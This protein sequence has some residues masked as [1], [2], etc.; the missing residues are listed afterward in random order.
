MRTGNITVAEVDTE[1]LKIVHKG[2]PTT[3]R[4]VHPSMIGAHT[5]RKLLNSSQAEATTAEAEVSETEEVSKEC[6][7]EAV[8]TCQ[9]E[10]EDAAT[11]HSGETAVAETSEV[12]TEAIITEVASMKTKTRTTTISKRLTECMMMTGKETLLNESHTRRQTV[13]FERQTNIDVG[14]R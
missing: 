6:A 10:D 12:A 2:I 3:A 13:V 14:L 8:A 11:S 9:C 4:N 5:M 1:I 7:A